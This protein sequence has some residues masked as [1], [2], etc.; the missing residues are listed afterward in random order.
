[1]GAGVGFGL[2]QLEFHIEHWTK[3]FLFILMEKCVRN[4]DFGRSNLMKDALGM[5]GSL[6]TSI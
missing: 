6:V 5:Y 3:I 1:M 4:G 2:N